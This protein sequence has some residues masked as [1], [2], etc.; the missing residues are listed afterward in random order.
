MLQERGA[1]AGG[2]ACLRARFV[3]GELVRVKGVFGR[4]KGQAIRVK[5][6]FVCNMMTASGLELEADHQLELAG[7]FVDR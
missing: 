4:A 3:K 2:A 6:A 7:G 5:C 1:E